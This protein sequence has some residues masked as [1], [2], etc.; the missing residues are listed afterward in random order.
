MIEQPAL[1]AAVR[2]P[3]VWVRSCAASACG[4]CAAG[5]GCGAGWLLRC[6]GARPGKPLAFHSADAHAVGDRVVLIIPARWRL[7]VACV[8]YGT[9][10]LGLLAGALMGERA[11]AEI[12]A[13]LLGATGLLL[14]AASASALGGKLA[15][16]CPLSVRAAETANGR[17]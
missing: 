13:I 4:A 7:L 12:G 6:F 17:N 14:G 9:P 5:H 1:V 10:L 8:T 11:G 2:Y 15:R 16:T 3:T